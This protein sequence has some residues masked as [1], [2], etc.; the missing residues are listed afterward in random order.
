M[1]FCNIQSR[2][3]CIIFLWV[4]CFYATDKN[5]KSTLNIACTY[6]SIKVNHSILQYSHLSIT[7]KLYRQSLGALSGSI[8]CT[9]K[10]RTKQQNHTTY[11]IRIYT[12]FMQ[13]ISMKQALRQ[14]SSQCTP[15]CMHYSDKQVKSP[16]FY[17]KY[18]TLAKALLCAVLHKCL[19]PP[20][21]MDLQN[22]IFYYYKLSQNHDISINV[23]CNIKFIYMF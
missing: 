7:T 10:S 11:L 19:H 8:T 9:R 22:K 21:N 23:A 13:V 1:C 20:I 14:T 4:I 16:P 18:K 5:I 17:Y 3:Y 6:Q 15:A 12:Y 2:I